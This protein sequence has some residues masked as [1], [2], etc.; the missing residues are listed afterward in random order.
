VTHPTRS[1]VALPAVV[2]VIRDER[3]SRARPGDHVR[4]RA[5][6]PSAAAHAARRGTSTGL[7]DDPVPALP[8]SHL[9]LSRL[10]VG[11]I[12]VKG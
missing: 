4:V 5:L 1:T 2:A 3:A 8:L 6:R 9:R 12:V 11:F 10:C 7:A